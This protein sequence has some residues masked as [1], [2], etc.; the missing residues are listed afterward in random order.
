MTSTPAPVFKLP[1]FVQEDA[2]EVVAAK[3]SAVATALRVER[4]V[5]EDQLEAV[6]RSLTSVAVKD[7]DRAPVLENMRLHLPDRNDKYH[8]RRRVQLHAKRRKLVDK[9]EADVRSWI[10]AVLRWKEATR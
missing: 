6:I 5:S 2:R 8:A 3:F 7:L 9:T 4:R 10:D 1:G